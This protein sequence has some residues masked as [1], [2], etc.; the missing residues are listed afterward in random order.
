M[1]ETRTASTFNCDACRRTCVDQGRA[2][3]EIAELITETRA[4]LLAD[5]SAAGR[6]L[7]EGGQTR[8]EWRVAHLI[9][10]IGRYEVPAVDE[11]EARRLRVQIEAWPQ[12]ADAQIE[13]RAVATAPWVAVDQEATD[14]R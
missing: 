14:A 12:V 10:D 7:P 3:V 2:A 1:P 9:E 11:E 6:L 4:K 8:T 5:L 13:S